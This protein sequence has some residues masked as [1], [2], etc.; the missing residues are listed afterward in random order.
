MYVDN[1]VFSNE[2]IFIDQMIFSYLLNKVK[3]SYFILYFIDYRC[4]E[5]YDKFCENQIST[6]LVR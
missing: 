6:N 1:A 2:K 3:F 5:E 4:E